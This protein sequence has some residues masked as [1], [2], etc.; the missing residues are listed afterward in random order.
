MLEQDVG[1]RESGGREI[2]GRRSRLGLMTLPL[3]GRL[4]IEAAIAGRT[5]AGIRFE[6]LLTIGEEIDGQ[7][8]PADS[9]E[10]W[11]TVCQRLDAIA[12]A[13]RLIEA[14]LIAGNTGPGLLLPDKDLLV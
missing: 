9:F 6:T 3:E 2:D 10:A 11:A 4:A 12:Y 7:V 1:E 5:P 13:L 14:Q 8:V